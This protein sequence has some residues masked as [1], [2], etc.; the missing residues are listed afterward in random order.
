MLSYAGE[1]SGDDHQ[2]IQELDQS[3][4]INFDEDPDCDHCCHMTTHFLGCLMMHHIDVLIM[5][6]QALQLDHN[7][8]PPGFFLPPYHPP[9]V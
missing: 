4:T 1:P 5:S 7:K 6:N 8:Y 3:Q 2:I 9:I